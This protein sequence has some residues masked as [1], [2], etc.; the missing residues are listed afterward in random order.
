MT[1]SKKI[2]KTRT[3]DTDD[4][5][6]DSIVTAEII[7]D[8][9]LSSEESDEDTAEGSRT[10]TGDIIQVLDEVN[11]KKK[12][13]GQLKQ[14]LKLGGRTNKQEKVKQ[15]DHDAAMKTLQEKKTAASKRAIET[16]K[17][18]LE[19]TRVESMT[20]DYRQKTYMMA[21]CFSDGSTGR[22]THDMVLQ[23]FKNLDCMNVYDKYIK[24][25][26]IDIN[27][28]PPRRTTK[29]KSNNKDKRPTTCLNDHKD[30]TKFRVEEDEGY[31]QVGKGLHLTKCHVC[32]C[33][34][35]PKKDEPVWVCKGS[36]IH[37]CKVGYCFQHDDIFKQKRARKK[38][39]YT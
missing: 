19:I 35:M 16:K 27:M 9:T 22:N 12:V 6:D 18:D 32:H 8:S 20:Y 31:F 28:Q 5:E 14:R 26:N 11:T 23:D 30:P 3:E 4:I 24:D 33:H 15:R 25:N 1:L 10:L 13:S 7:Q 36:A 29:K 34:L 21:V 2:K 39:K 38:V 17:N 37:E